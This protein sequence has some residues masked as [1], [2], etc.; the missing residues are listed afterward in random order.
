VW[1]QLDS[2]A[3]AYCRACDC[4][5]LCQEH[6][7][8]LRLHEFLR[9]LRPEFEQLRV[10]L[11]ARSPLPTMVEAVNLAQ[12]EEIHLRGVLSSS[13]TVLA[14]T[15]GSTTSTPVSATPSTPSSALAPTSGPV[16]QGGTATALFCRYCKSKT[17][18]IEQCQRCPSHRKGG[19][20]TS[21]SAR[22]SS[23]QQ[24][25]EWVLELT[26]RMD[27]LEHGVAPPNPSKVSSTTTQSP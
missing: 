1:H 21:A 12:V 23:S 5:C 11:L 8:V 24:P 15:A 4:C 20:S 2:L 19:S 27:H 13:A 6:D 17:H 10:Q 26:R 25:S 9:R 18:E 22:G 14:T 7:S 16:T 3:P